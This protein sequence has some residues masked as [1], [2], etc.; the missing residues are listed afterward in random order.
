MNTKQKI[1]HIK[2]LNAEAEALRKKAEEKAEYAQHLAS[3]I[4]IAI[5][6]QEE[7]REPEPEIQEFS[8]SD[9][10]KNSSIGYFAIAFKDGIQYKIRVDVNMR[11]FVY[12]FGQLHSSLGK[13]DSLNNAIEVMKAKGYMPK[14]H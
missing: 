13:A 2:R 5:P 9:F 10:L 12:H 8:A 1:Y 11:I 3:S 4:G 6:A 14:K 7:M